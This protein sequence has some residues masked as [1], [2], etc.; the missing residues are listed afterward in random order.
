MYDLQ[1]VDKATSESSSQNK[2]TRCFLSPGNWTC[3]CFSAVLS[4]CLGEVCGTHGLNTHVVMD[5]STKKL[6]PF[7]NY[8]SYSWRS[9]RCILMAIT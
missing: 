1:R 8:I 9:V 7:V 3:L 6:E 4:Q 5:F 2:L